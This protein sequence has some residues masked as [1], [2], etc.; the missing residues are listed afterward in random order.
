M[1]FCFAAIHAVAVFGLEGSG[2]RAKLWTEDSKRNELHLLAL[3]PFT[4]VF[5]SPGEQPGCQL[6]CVSF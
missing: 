6:F 3:L 5:D 1:L 4:F 2:L